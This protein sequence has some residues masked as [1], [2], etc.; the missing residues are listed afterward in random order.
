Q[1][2]TGGRVTGIDKSEAM[3][4]LARQRC[5]DLS[6]VELT[7]GVAESLS[8]EDQ[9]F[10]ALA[11]TQVLLY[12][13]DVRQALNEMRRVLKPGGRIAVV[14]TDWRGA[15]LN[16]NEQA[17]TRKIT[18]GWDDAVPSPN[19]PVQLGPLLREHD[20]SAIRVEA[21]PV[22]NTSYA[23]DGF[24]VSMTKSI[25]ASA[26]ERGVV[27]EAQARTWLDDLERLE[28]EGAYFFCVN[29]FLFFR[30]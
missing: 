29:R 4:K 15:V 30:R 25:A 7:Q 17:L 22:L 28:W 12:I 23:P 11:C 1:V 10:H 21:I 20:F 16:S 19:L 9:S 18:R 27:S 3:L 14:E 26:Q 24:S 8:A 13:P 6:Q 5:A 2:G